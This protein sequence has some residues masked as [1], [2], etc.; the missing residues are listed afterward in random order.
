MIERIE[1]LKNKFKDEWLA[2]KVIKENEAGQVVECELIAHNR[3]KRDLHR[4][5]R[6][7][8]VQGVY[9]TYAG[10]I[11]KPEYAVMFNE[12]SN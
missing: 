1:E 9:I 11:V 4:K 8:E 10:P 12:N 6:E 7:K 2:L 5:L 3:N